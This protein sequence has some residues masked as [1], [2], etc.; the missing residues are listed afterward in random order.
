M[1]SF[2]NT[3]H[4]NCHHNHH[5]VWWSFEAFENVRPSLILSLSGSFIIFT[6]KGKIIF[7]QHCSISTK[8]NTKSWRVRILIVWDII[9]VSSWWGALCSIALLPNTHIYQILPN[10]CQMFYQNSC[11]KTIDLTFNLR[12]WRDSCI[13]MIYFIIRRSTVSTVFVFEF[14]FVFCLF[15]DTFGHPNNQLPFPLVAAAVDSSR[16]FYQPGLRHLLHMSRKCQC[17][18]D[19]CWI[20]IVIVIVTLI[21]IE[22]SLNDMQIINQ[23]FGTSCKSQSHENFIVTLICKLYFAHICNLPVEVFI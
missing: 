1:Q 5:F 10:T 12:R 9:L 7:S 15:G 13:V 19:Y 2:I 3:L 20:V 6:A 14:V 18:N 16:D 21:L 23:V 4:L 8:F 11:C 17:H 22:L